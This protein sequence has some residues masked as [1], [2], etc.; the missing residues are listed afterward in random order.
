MGAFCKFKISR[1][2]IIGIILSMTLLCGCKIQ[3]EENEYNGEDLT[4]VKYI[5]DTHR[6][7][8]YSGNNK[9]YFESLSKNGY[10]IIGSEYT[11]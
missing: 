9:M 10:W 4:V 3:H 8:Q 11:E 5:D 1:I 2:I 6:I 7:V